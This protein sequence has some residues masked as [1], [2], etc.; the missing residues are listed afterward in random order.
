MREQVMMALAERVA[1]FGEH[2][3]Y[4]TTEVVTNPETHRVERVPQHPRER[5]EDDLAVGATPSRASRPRIQVVEAAAIAG[6]VI[7]LVE[8]DPAALVELDPGRPQ[9][10]EAR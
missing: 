8:G 4:A 3:A 1:N 2:C 7:A 6:A 9:R 5:V 10:G